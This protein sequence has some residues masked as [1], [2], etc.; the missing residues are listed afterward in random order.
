LADRGSSGVAGGQRCDTAGRVTAQPAVLDDSAPAEGEAV[1]VS[2]PSALLRRLESL[3]DARGE[4]LETVMRETL[5]AALPGAES[6]AGGPAQRGYRWKDV[7][8]PEGTELCFTH[9]GR[10]YGAVVTGGRILHEGEPVTPSRFINAVAGPGRNAW[11]GLWVRRPADAVWVL[12]DDLRRAAEVAFVASQAV[13]IQQGE[14]AGQRAASQGSAES[15]T[16]S[17]QRDT[18]LELI[19][20]IALALG[21][22]PRDSMGSLPDSAPRLPASVGGVSPTALRMLR[23]VRRRRRTGP[24]LQAVRQKE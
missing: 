12:A 17:A 18:A 2:L 16:P 1:R 21:S 24:G 10:T 22:G 7:F 8:L 9:K 5:E 13:A 20:R 6:P 23:T 19:G 3:A 14:A 11:I 4:S 15:K